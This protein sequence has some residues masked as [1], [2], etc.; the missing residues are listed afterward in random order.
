MTDYETINNPYEQQNG[1]YDP[2]Y[3]NPHNQGQQGNPPPQGNPG[4]G[5]YPPQPN[6]QGTYPPPQPNNYPPQ[7]GGNYPPQQG[8]N[9]PP[10]NPQG[11]FPPQPN[12]GGANYPPQQGSYPPQG[13]GGPPHGQGGPPQQ[14]F[15]QDAR[16][17]VK[18]GTQSGQPMENLNLVMMTGYFQHQRD[19]NNQ[20]KYKESGNSVRLGFII[21]EEQTWTDQS[22]QAQSKIVKHRCQAWNDFARNLVQVVDGTPIKVWG[23]LTRFYMRDD[24]NNITGELVDIKVNKYEFP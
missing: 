24:Q 14:G 2:N 8:G 23:N 6:Q 4:Q 5:N 7:Q 10:Q 3:N 13:Q 18:L 22:G 9:Y 17:I 16:Q 20:P 21:A 19:K 1:N 11:G 12:Q 15:G